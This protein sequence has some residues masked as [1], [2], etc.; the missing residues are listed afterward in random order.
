[1]RQNSAALRT[2][3]PPGGDV[4]HA[5]RAD[6]QQRIALQLGLIREAD[7]GRGSGETST[8]AVSGS[9][10]LPRRP[11]GSAGLSRP[12]TAFSSGSGGALMG[13]RPSTAGG[14]QPAPALIGLGG[15][16]TASGGLPS[17]GVRV[18]APRPVSAGNFLQQVPRP[19][20]ASPGAVRYGSPYVVARPANVG[21]GGG[22]PSR[23]PLAAA[24]RPSSGK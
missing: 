24:A 5:G 7:G 1:M 2:F 14:A 8:S 11:D 22:I 17:N 10:A 6:E 18:A 23:P 13:S 15:P 4:G 20:S 9:A 12:T 16:G 3:S 19:A 21:S